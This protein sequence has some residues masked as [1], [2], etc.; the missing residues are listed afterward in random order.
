MEL[1][2][3]LY[4]LFAVFESIMAN[5]LKMISAGASLYL[6]NFERKL[7]SDTLIGAGF[8]IMLLIGRFGAI[9]FLIFLA[10]KYSWYFPILLYLGGIG[11]SLFIISVFRIDA[12]KTQY[13]T[14]L[15]FITFPILFICMWGAA[16]A[17]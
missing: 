16:L 4:L 9:A 6:S 1:V 10:F 11:L 7:A 2:A 8:P 5:E 12:Y 15:G 3:I 17:R 14:I 13:I